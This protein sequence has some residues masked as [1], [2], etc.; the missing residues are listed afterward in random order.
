VT[1]HATATAQ[2]TV[3]KQTPPAKD[4]PDMQYQPR[5][6]VLEALAAAARNGTTDRGTRVSEDFM[7]RPNTIAQMR[8]AHP[9][10]D[11]GFEHA[12]FLD[13]WLSKPGP[14][15]RKLD[16]DR[17]WRNWIRTAASDRAT[18]RNGHTARGGAD[19]KAAAWQ[20][21]KTTVAE[22]KAIE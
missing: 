4:D 8:A 5:P 9:D 17:T 1:V 15:A 3:G 10:V 13:Y 7:P 22:P 14:A 2:V 6:T 18:P 16:W 21:L 11:L 12:K 19:A 20:A